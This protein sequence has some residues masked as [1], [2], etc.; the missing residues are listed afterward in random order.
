MVTAHLTSDLIDQL[1]S[2]SNRRAMVTFL[3]HQ[4][5]LWDADVVEGLY[6]SVV[7]VARADLRQ[8]ERLADAAMWL[9]DKLGDDRCRAQSLRAVGHVLLIRR[10]YSGSRPIAITCSCTADRSPTELAKASARLKRDCPRHLTF[11]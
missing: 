6:E 7:R 1:A 10:K 4:P 8:A 5:Q 3:R 2:Q 11:E 9:A